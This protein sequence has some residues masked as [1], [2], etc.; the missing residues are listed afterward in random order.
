MKKLIL[1][2][3]IA[4]TF[5]SCSPDEITDTSTKCKC[6]EITQIYYVRYSNG[7]CLRNI[8][9]KNNCSG[10]TSMIQTTVGNVGEQYCGN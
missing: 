6:G 1:I 4:L 8:K 3:A 5:L 7:Q 9:V 10:R 2:S